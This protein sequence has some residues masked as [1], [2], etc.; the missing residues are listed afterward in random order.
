MK[1]NFGYFFRL[2]SPLFSCPSL[3]TLVCR[4]HKLQWAKPAKAVDE[5]LV[6]LKTEQGHLPGPLLHHDELD[7][8]LVLL[9]L[10]GLRRARFFV[11]IHPKSVYLLYPNGSRLHPLC[12][13]QVTLPWKEP[14]LLTHQ[15]T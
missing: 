5:A 9:L 6:N 3:A 15:V 10:G 8:G 7:L 12:T 13:N 4:N 14:D 2:V 1:A 11:R